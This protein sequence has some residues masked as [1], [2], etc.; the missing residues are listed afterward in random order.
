MTHNSVEPTIQDLLH[1]GTSCVRYNN[2]TYQVTVTDMTK[3]SPD[4]N[5]ELPLSRPVPPQPNTEQLESILHL[6]GCQQRTAGYNEAKQGKELDMEHMDLLEKQTLEEVMAWNKANVIE[7]Q[8]Q[9][10]ERV[11]LHRDN[12]NWTAKAQR[13]ANEQI[14]YIVS[15]LADRIAE[16]NK[17]GETN[18]NHQEV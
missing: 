16:L 12:P 13:I 6:N 17:E 9:L 15:D 14:D 5:S 1:L 8:Q 18:G 4:T 2:R 3:N 11:K 7:A 10:I